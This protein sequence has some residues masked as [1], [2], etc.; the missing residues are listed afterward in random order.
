MARSICLYFLVYKQEHT[1]SLGDKGVECLIRNVKI[2]VESLKLNDRVRK[3]LERSVWH[4]CWELKHPKLRLGD[5]I[6]ISFGNDSDSG[7]GVERLSDLLDVKD[8][9]RE[10][11]RKFYV[12]YLWMR[13]MVALFPEIR[14]IEGIILYKLDL[15]QWPLDLDLI[16]III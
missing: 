11:T 1:K 2:Y 14:N 8:R 9:E 7:C 13:K 15:S 6:N 16:F 5:Q 3:V 10:R 12:S 4:H